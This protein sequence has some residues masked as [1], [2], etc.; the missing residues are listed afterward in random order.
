[1]SRKSRIAR[2]LPAPHFCISNPPR[3]PRSRAEPIALVLHSVV[4]FG[5]VADGAIRICQ[6]RLGSLG[7]TGRSAGLPAEPVPPYPPT[8]HHCAVSSRSAPTSTA[9]LSPAMAGGFRTTLRRGARTIGGAHL[10]QRCAG[11][12]PPYYSL[13]LSCLPSLPYARTRMDFCERGRQRALF[14]SSS[15]STP[16]LVYF[17]LHSICDFL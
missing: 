1:M 4:H 6:H 12:C 16:L 2:L 5:A 17:A 3:P 8:P 11:L 9:L 7:G 14:L 13:A 10:V 15:I